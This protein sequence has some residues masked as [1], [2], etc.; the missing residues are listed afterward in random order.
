MS[1]AEPITI[2]PEDISIEF[3]KNLLGYLEETIGPDR[4]YNKGMSFDPGHERHNRLLD[5]AEPL[6]VDLW[7]RQAWSAGDAEEPEPSYTLPMEP[8]R[9]VA[10]LDA[11]QVLVKALG[12][13]GGRAD[14]KTGTY[15]LRTVLA[16]WAKEAGGYAYEQTIAK[17][18]EDLADAL[19]AAQPQDL[20]GLKEHTEAQ[21]GMA[22]KERESF[23]AILYYLRASFALANTVALRDQN[24]ATGMMRFVDAA[25]GNENLPTV[26]AAQDGDEGPVRAHAQDFLKAFKALRMTDLE[27]IVEEVSGEQVP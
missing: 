24:T 4:R 15:Y 6:V 1:A 21:E 13:P 11:L 22:R 12:Q 5:S 3:A 7:R 25:L 23:G 27:T 16:T 19:T 2:N 18:C 17:A 26:Y 10:I 20:P 8:R 9:L 14:S